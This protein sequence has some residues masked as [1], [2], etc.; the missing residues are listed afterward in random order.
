MFWNALGAHGLFPRA[1]KE[2]MRYTYLLVNFFTII[3]PFIFSFHPKLNF[4]KTWSAFFPAVFITGV[5]FIAWDVYFTSL[6]VWGFN[7]QHLVG[8]EVF[9][10]PLEEIL[11]FFCIPYACVFTYHCLDIFLG[12]ILA[13]PSE[14]FITLLLIIL[15]LVFG[16]IHYDRLYTVTTFLSFAAMLAFAKWILK[17]NWLGKFY[18]IYAVLLIP[19]FLVNGVLTGTGLEEPVVWYNEEEFMGYRMITIPVEDTFYGMELI[20]MNL[21]IYKY[22]LSRRRIFT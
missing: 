16:A 15:L 6:G 12:N 19:F 22:I 17:V 18:F 8:V 20:L 5:I 3:I 9:N 2:K 11:F 10:L 21:L 13:G 4:H 7:S 1:K 14:K